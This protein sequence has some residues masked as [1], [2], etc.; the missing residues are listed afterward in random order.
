MQNDVAK[1]LNKYFST[2]LKI[3]VFFPV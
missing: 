2:N 1:M 3:Y